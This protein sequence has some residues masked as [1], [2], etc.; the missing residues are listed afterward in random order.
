MVRIYACSYK[1]CYRELA[2]QHVKHKEICMAPVAT[3][4]EK[5]K[6]DAATWV[7]TVISLIAGMVSILVYFNESYV[8]KAELERE[9]EL[10]MI[11][12]T[13]I[14]DNLAEI[15]K[16]LVKSNNRIAYEI[17]Q[18]KLFSLTTRRDVL[19]TRHKLTSDEQ[20][21]LRFLQ[22][23]INELNSSMQDRPDTEDVSLNKDTNK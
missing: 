12:Q 17:K 6:H 10:R 8:S 11:A 1:Y 13:Q 7:A 15:K 9:Q 20:V 21:E 5:T 18:T 23:K 22:T 16:S 4:K 2:L 19:Q 14:N 3:N